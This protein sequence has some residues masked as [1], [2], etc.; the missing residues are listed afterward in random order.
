MPALSRPGLTHG[1]KVGLVSKGAN[2]PSQIGTSRKQDQIDRGE[3]NRRYPALVAGGSGQPSNMDRARN[4]AGV[5]TRPGDSLNRSLSNYLL[6]GI[7][8]KLI[9]VLDQRD[10]Y[11]KS[12]SD[13]VAHYS[14]EIGKHLGLDSDTM[15]TLY[16]AGLLH[17]VGK[18]GI[19]DHI[20]NK[21]GDLT[22][23]EMEL[24]K[25]HPQLAVELIGTEGSFKEIAEAVYHHHER[26]DGTGYPDGLAG[27]QIP[28]LARILAVADAFSAM[29]TDRPYRPAMSIMNAARE[30]VDEAGKQF[31]PVLVTIFVEKVLGIPLR[32][33]LERS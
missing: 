26:Y 14:I 32:E 9:A 5:D 21:R 30:L 31:D 29:T 7:L 17:D 33:L 6:L 24:M 8:A 23:E 2:N 10:S 18:I 27:D 1:E 3:F 20:L 25:R 11:T 4:A 28:L 16:V 22:D 12:H 13:D 15:Q 19:S